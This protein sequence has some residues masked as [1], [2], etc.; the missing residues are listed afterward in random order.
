[1]YIQVNMHTA[2]EGT[3]EILLALLEDKGYEGFEETDEGLKAFIPEA[4]FDKAFIEWL[5]NEHKVSFDTVKLEQQNWNELWETSFQPVV[6]GSFCAIRADFHPPANDVLH[7]IIITPK[8]SF[9]TGHHATT[10]LMVQQMKDMDFSGK[11]VLDFGTGTGILAILAEK[12]GAHEILAVDNDEW[13]YG[14]AKENIER[15]NIKNIALMQGSLEDIPQQEYDIILANINRHILLQ[16]MQ[17]LSQLLKNEGYILM[18]GLLEE[19]KKIILASAAEAGFT[20]VKGTAAD[21]WIS[22][23][24][25]K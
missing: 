22:I 6:I 8:M 13:S 17:Q 1:M 19:D 21:N 10:R 20:E 7:E 14:N 5:A 12:L 18:S 15:N 16:Y 25:R 23:L 24:F 11:R 4:D 3:R 2:D 9:G